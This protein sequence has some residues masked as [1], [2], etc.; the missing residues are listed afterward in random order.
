MK[1]SKVSFG[2][3]KPTGYYAN[4]KVMI[5]VELNDHECEQKALNLAK[6]IAEKFFYDNNPQLKLDGLQNTVVHE[7]VIQDKIE[8]PTGSLEE[9][10][11]WSIQNATTI[12]EL[13]MFEKTANNPKYPNLK[14]EYSNKLKELSNN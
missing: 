3:T 8:Q 1:I 12:K 9:R 2:F 13:E 6:E 14:T 11:K 7:T 5:E 10:F 4:E